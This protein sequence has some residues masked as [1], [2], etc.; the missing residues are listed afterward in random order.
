MLVFAAPT[1][2]QHSVGLTNGRK[3]SAHGKRSAGQQQ[4]ITRRCSWWRQPGDGGSVMFTLPSESSGREETL[5][6]LML[7]R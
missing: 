7:F 4:W 1:L 5:R 3:R 6:R 2:I